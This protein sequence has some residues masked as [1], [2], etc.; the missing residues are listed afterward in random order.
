MKYFIPLVLLLYIPAARA[1]LIAHYDFSDGN[2]YDNEISNNYTLSEKKSKGSSARV[3]RGK[4]DGISTAII[5]QKKRGQNHFAWLETEAGLAPEDFTVSFWFYTDKVNQGGDYSGLFASGSSFQRGNWQLHS[6][7]SK[8]GRIAFMDGSNKKFEPGKL[9][10]AKKWYHLIIRKD[11]DAPDKHTTVYLTQQ[12][13]PL[14]APVYT[15]G[16][17]TATLSAFR[18]GINRVSNQSYGMHLANI[19]IYDD[20][21]VS[22][23]ALLKDGPSG[24]GIK[25]QPKKTPTV[26]SSFSANDLYVGPDTPVTLSWDVEN[27]TTLNITPNIGDVTQLSENGTGS[28]TVRIKETTTF[29]LT[30]GKGKSTNTKKKSVTVKVGPDRPNI[31]VF[32]VDDM[33]PQDTSV[34]F[35]VDPDG[36]PIQYNFNSFYQTPNMETLAS[37]GM[38]FTTAYAHA[39]CSPSRCSLITGR[40]SARHAVTDWV[41]ANDRGSPPNWRY[42]GLDTTDVTLPTQLRAAGYR[43]I[44]VGKAHFSLPEVKPEQLGFDINIGGTNA[45][46]PH[47][48]YINNPGYKGLPGLE[49][50]DGS[51]F[52]TRALT[53]EAKKAITNAAKDGV[54][55]YLNMC[56]YAVHTPF[57]TNP[58]ATG[59]YS[60]AVSKKHKQFATMIEGVDISV[61]EIHQ[62]LIELGIAENT[63]ILFLSDNGSDSPATT[64]NDLPKDDFS[65]WPMR[66][67]K[68][69]KWEGG[70]RIPLI[71]C[72][73]KTAPNTVFQK[74]VPITNNSI[75]TDIV[76]AWD[77][78][79]T[80]LDIVGVPPMKDFGEDGYSLVPYLKGI[81]GNHRPQEIVFHYPH[82]HR[83]KFYSWIRIDD[84]KLIYNFKDNS[85][86]LY[87]LAS[88]PTE[89]TN[90]ASSQ[91]DTT[92]MMARA[93]AEKLDATWGPSGVLLPIIDSSAPEGN[94]VSIPH[95]PSVD[96]DQDGLPDN[97]EDANSNGLVD[98]GETSPDN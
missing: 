93:L 28:K 16:D 36:K 14:G 74:A 83:S 35:N 55:F 31:V 5:P 57:T 77:L 22:L 6:N 62:K 81:P 69:T 33:G 85:H 8:K 53:R 30:A 42:A 65:D 27:A 48:G 68:A 3:T 95:S 84:L 15:S 79:V 18:F 25:K 75:E 56:Y 86:Q 90:L 78:P 71:A 98:V 89:S 70:C 64:S 44:H 47:G 7:A 20:S 26:I 39:V 58:E 72:W 45:G 59:D 67:K 34:A 96:I 21:N 66:G 63:L 49:D 54:P 23:K 43:T 94:V 60:R 91:P 82:S 80:I 40:N 97:T 4:V 2:L 24:T 61:G 76:S 73:G 11:S 1:D 87:N 10:K 32:L 13:K 46:T 19:R 12:G 50:Y 88:D 37:T 52:L 38:R 17:N 92:M 9:H 41:N 29:T 51:E